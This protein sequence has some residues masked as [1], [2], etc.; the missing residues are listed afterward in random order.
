MQS[1]LIANPFTL[2]LL[3]S[4]RLDC[5]LEYSWKCFGDK[6]PQNPT[7]LVAHI[8]PPRWRG[9]SN[10]SR[11]KAS[12]TLAGSRYLSTGLLCVRHHAKC[13]E[14]SDE[15]H[16][17]C[18][19]WVSAFG[20]P[21]G[22][23]QSQV[24]PHSSVLTKC[25]GNTY[26]DPPAPC[27]VLCLMVGFFCPESLRIPDLGWLL[28]RLTKD[29]RGTAHTSEPSLYRPLRELGR[30]TSDPFHHFSVDTHCRSTGTTSLLTGD[31]GL[32]KIWLS[33]PNKKDK[34]FLSRGLQEGRFRA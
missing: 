4:I 23:G 30:K 8:M 5:C 27:L 2:S 10:L 13:R 26:S 16:L 18:P 31:R 19:L 12:L 21:R 34:Q 1:L 11:K 25:H 33:R 15:K 22:R 9:C 28:G 29:S 32:R 24:F 7:P 6:L 17:P 14:E 20:T 3:A